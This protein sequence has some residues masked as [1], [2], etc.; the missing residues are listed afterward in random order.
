MNPT[1]LIAAVA[2]AVREFGGAPTKTKIL[3]LLYLLDIESYRKAGVTLTG[4]DWKFYRYGPWA[5][6]YD[7]VLQAAA[8]AN[9]ISINSPDADESATFVNPT[10]KVLLAAVFPSVVQEL[11]A[12]RIIE[13]WASRPTV[14]L[15]D[16]VYFH[17]PPMRDA[18]RNE[19]LDFST[20]TREEKLPHYTGIKSQLD[21]KQKQR[22]R[23]ELLRRLNSATKSPIAPLDPPPRYDADYWSALAKLDSDVD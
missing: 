7:A 13:T 12:K 8:Q 20:I 6:S 4:F 1:D 19:P 3:K 22:K 23:K 9:K 11:M 14:E 2:T 5:T 18:V 17:T 10:Q 15:L 21:E 16:Y